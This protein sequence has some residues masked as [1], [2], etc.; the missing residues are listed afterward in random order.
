[1]EYKKTGN[2]FVNQ[3]V[4]SGQMMFPACVPNDIRKIASIA[5][6]SWCTYSKKNRAFYNLKR[7]FL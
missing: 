4:S 6:A 5:V 7:N 1:M 3:S 2:S